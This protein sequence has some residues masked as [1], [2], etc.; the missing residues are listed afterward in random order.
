MDYQKEFENW[1][2][3]KELDPEL[4]KQLLKM[5]SRNLLAAQ[6]NLVQQECGDYWVLELVK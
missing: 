6:W 2:N 3:F 1:L 5:R 4:K